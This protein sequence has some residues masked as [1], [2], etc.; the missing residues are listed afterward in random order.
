M[1]N[2]CCE[3][4]IV[5]HT[6]IATSDANETSV[7]QENDEDAVGDEANES[8]TTVNQT[9]VRI[10]NDNSSENDV[11]SYLKRDENT[12]EKF[13][14]EISNLPKYVCY[15]DLKKLLQNKFHLKTQKIKLIGKGA[16]FAFV[17]F[18]S[19][20][21]RE[22]AIEKC[23]GF[24][25]K[26]SQLK[27]KKA[28][29]APDPLVKK[30]KMHE[31]S[32]KGMKKQITSE[33]FVN[34]IENID[35][36]LND[37]VAPLWK[38]SYEQQ[39]ETKQQNYKD[40]LLELYKEIG[41]IDKSFDKNFP[42]LFKWWKTAKYVYGSCC[43][44]EPIKASPVIVG[45][46]NKCEFNIGNDKT[47]GFRLGLYKDGNVTVVSPP[48]NCPLLSEK[49]YEV[50]TQL[51]NFLKHI[52][53]LSAF[54]NETHEGHWRQ[55][56]VRTTKDDCMI[57]VAVHPQNKSEMELH[58]EVKKLKE[59]LDSH[60]SNKITSCYLH[61][62]AKRETVT[63]NQSQIQLVD[64]ES[65]IRES[66]KNATLHF[67]ISPFAFFQTNTAAAEVCYNTI[68][69]LARLSQNTI[70][71]DICCGTGTIGLY[72]ASQV[73]HVIGI[74]LNEDAIKDCLRNAELNGIK[75]VDY[76]CGKAEA[77]IGLA[78]NKAERLLDNSQTI[79]FVCIIDPPRA[80]LNNPIVKILRATSA[81]NRLVYVSCEPRIAKRNLIDLCRPPSKQY[82][83]APFVPVK[84]VPIDMFPHTRHCELLIL[85]ERL[86]EDLIS[87]MNAIKHENDAENN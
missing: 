76:I 86:S 73:K 4:P 87:S 85:Y 9:A 71:L 25:F 20:S 10:E 37:Q 7:K 58:E 77:V 17:A 47:V 78:I 11:Y 19:E 75:N 50:A 21:D 28:N 36:R 35:D 83:E 69:D 60:C 66:M 53:S 2:D 62:F 16:K 12:C 49:M 26:G 48:K 13:K 51:E 31:S 44:L 70:L 72:L 81:I 23:N 79:E 63:P 61:C 74:E 67:S 52:S 39:L 32:E 43:R 57:I 46:R 34:Y 15:A 80:G 38:L 45:Y 33:E 65:H 40:F 6:E 24:S 18:K 14:V 84:A 42:L 82:K 59:F 30:R 55:L 5:E 1:E 54:N 29:P 41:K 64:G 3:R 22:I 8:E 56:T 68:A 27:A